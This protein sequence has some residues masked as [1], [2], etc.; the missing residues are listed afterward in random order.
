V[1][2]LPALVLL[3]VAA[4][5]VATAAELEPVP[6]AR[7]AEASRISAVALAGVAALQRDD[8]LFADPTGRVVGSSGLPTLA[9]G[10]APRRR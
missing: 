2:A 10:R 1:F 9:W 3:A 4:A 5:P 7:P 8:G 6:A